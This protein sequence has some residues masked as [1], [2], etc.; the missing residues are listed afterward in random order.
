M[1]FSQLNLKQKLYHRSSQL[2]TIDFGSRK[3]HFFSLCALNS[4]LSANQTKRCEAGDKSMFS[5]NDI[6]LL[7]MVGC[8]WALVNHPLHS[9]DTEIFLPQIP[10]ALIIVYTFTLYFFFFLLR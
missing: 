9:L 1:F 4:S 3:F 5:G 10:M 2:L 7:Q 6:G 8:S